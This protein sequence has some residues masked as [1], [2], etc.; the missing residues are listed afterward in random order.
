[1]LV[2]GFVLVA[3]RRARNRLRRVT[4]SSPSKV[5]GRRARNRLRRVNRSSPSKVVCSS[6]YQNDRFV[7]SGRVRS[8]QRHFRDVMYTKPVD[9]QRCLTL[10]RSGVVAWTTPD[11]GTAK[12]E[13]AK[14]RGLTARRSIECHLSGPVAPFFVEE[15]EFSPGRQ[16]FC[17]GRQRMSE[18]CS[19]FGSRA[20]L[21][22]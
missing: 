2:S 13:R 1:M 20:S 4:R 6:S 12:G 10:D 17:T 22:L 8:M 21:T 18:N 14:S 19:N 11:A 5:V 7:R 9:V 3:G 16:S 15:S